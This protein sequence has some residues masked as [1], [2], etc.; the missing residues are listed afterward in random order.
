[1]KI[2]IV[3]TGVEEIADKLFAVIAV[4]AAGRSYTH[5]FHFDETTDEWAYTKAYR[6]RSKVDQA[7]EIDPSRWDCYVPY[8]SD[9]WDID[10]MEVTLM[11]DEERHEK[12]WMFA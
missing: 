1:M 10:G 2:K 8:G 6:L 3:R 11:D 12:E 7:G 5:W 9:A 4:D